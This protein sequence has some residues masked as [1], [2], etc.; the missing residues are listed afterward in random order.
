VHRPANILA[1]DASGD[2]S[3]IGVHTAAG[4]V[5]EV[6]TDAGRKH[7]RDLIP[8]VRDLLR[9]AG[10]RPM[11]LDLI[12]VGLGPGSYTGMRIGLTA[13]RTLAYAAG[14]RLAG[15]DSLEAVA[16]NAPADALRVAVVGDAQRGDVYAADFA[17]EAPGATLVSLGPSRIEPLPAWAANLPPDALVLGVG[18]RSATIRASL[19]RAV[20]VDPDAPIHRPSGRRL[21]DL[22]L[23][24]LDAP[25][26]DPDAL[27]PNYLRRSAAE[28]QWDA[29]AARP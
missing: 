15:L 11:D 6:E 5:F 22:A 21:I 29:R 26:I 7:G 13:A 25:A 16:Q 14:A 2:R 3:T 10:V 24:A 4:A 9:R 17:R 18:L 8:A 27:E 12:A 19:P 20:D 23:R 28:D 1:L